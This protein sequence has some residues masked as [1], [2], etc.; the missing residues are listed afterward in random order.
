MAVC[1]VSLEITP[2]KLD[3]PAVL[4]RRAGLLGTGVRRVNVIARRDRQS[5]LNA[6]LELSRLGFEPVWHLTNRGRRFAGLEAEID[7][8]ASGGIARMLC[9]RGEYK[10]VDG[11][12]TPKLR[13][14]VRMLRRTIPDAS[15]GVT[16]D[17]HAG[18]RGLRNLWP[19][20][21]AG[22]DRVQSQVVFDLDPLQRLAD[23]LAERGSQVELIAMLLPVLSRSAALGISRRLS[24]PLPAMLE[25]QLERGAEPGGWSHFESLLYA[26]ARDER[27]G[28]VAIMT[29]M[30]PD[31]A[32]AMRL[33]AALGPLLAQPVQP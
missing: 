26:I 18:A 19:K 5:S 23:A 17:P 30:D 22:A 32:Y 9:V 20:L 21:D 7:R 12:E 31:P 14:V 28:G 16:V 27:F 29:P 33:R 8:A 6:S 24:I 3:R 15:V 4:L 10:A 2:P 11:A 13:E 25:E 1:N